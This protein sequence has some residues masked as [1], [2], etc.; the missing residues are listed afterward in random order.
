LKKF[1][2]MNITD[3]AL[4]K[5]EIAVRQLNDVVQSKQKDESL[6]QEENLLAEELT[7]LQDKYD[8]LHET[9]SDISGRL[10]T[11]IKKL[12]YILE[13]ENVSS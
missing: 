11:T 2:N 9:S 10:E 8:T 4:T 6:H 1:E 3:E 5:L 7:Q 13:E 12:K